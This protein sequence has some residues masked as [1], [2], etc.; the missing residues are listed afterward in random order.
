MPRSSL[1]LLALCAIALP[2]RAQKMEMA[3]MQKWASARTV[4]YSVEGVYNGETPVTPAMGGLADVVDRVNL[5]LEWIITEAKLVGVSAIQNA[6]AESSKLRDRE[7]KCLPPV[8]KGPLEFTLLEVGPGL[9]GAIDLRMERSYPPVEVAQFCSASR[10]TVA[11]SKKVDMMTI[12]VPS[13]TIMAMGLPPT[14]E[15]SYSADGK[16]MI[17]KQGNWSW[18]FTP[19][20]SKPK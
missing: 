17:V 4:H 2:A 19:S 6:R 18:T 13:P 10:K 12:M 15:L 7:P 16:S 1:V 3:A 14:K 20:L 9:G 5:N 11:A 8:L